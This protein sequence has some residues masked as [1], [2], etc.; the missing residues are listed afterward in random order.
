VL[1]KNEISTPCKRK[2]NFMRPIDA[3]IKEEMK[4]KF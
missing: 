3:I 2:K 4:I 1:R